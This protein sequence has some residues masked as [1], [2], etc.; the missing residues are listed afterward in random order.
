M[1][2]KSISNDIDECVDTFLK[3]SDEFSELEKQWF[4]D[5]ITD[6]EYHH[7]LDTYDYLSEKIA[8]HY[9]ANFHTAN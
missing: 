7:V 3:M 6:E 2:N 8:L 9:I 5:E 4:N 1:Y